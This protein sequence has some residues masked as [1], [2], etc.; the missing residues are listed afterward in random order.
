LTNFSAIEAIAILAG[1]AFPTGV[2]AQDTGRPTNYGENPAEPPKVTGAYAGD[3]QILQ[4]LSNKP[5]KRKFGEYGEVYYIPSTQ[6][7]TMWG[8]LPNRNSKPVMKVPSNS[9][10]VFDTVSHEGILEDQGR[11]PVSFFGKYGVPEEHVLQDA[12][13]IAASSVEHDFIKAG[14]HIVTG[15]VEIEG[16]QPGDVLMVETLEL[17]PRVPYGVVSNR[18]G[19]G[20]LVGE[21][22]ETERPD[23]TASATNPELY[24]NVSIFTPIRKVHNQWY[25]IMHNR[26]GEEVWFPVTPFLGIMGIAPN[27][28]DLVH[29]VPP[30]AH[31]GNLD[32]AKL[33][34]GSTLYL[35]IQVPGAMFYVGDPHNSQGNGEVAL[36]ALEQA[37]RAVLRL[38][39]LKDGNPRIPSS[40]KLAKPFGETKD[41]W[42]PIGLHED[43]DEAMKDAVRQAVNF[44]SEKLDMDRATALAYMS[45]AT[46]YEVSQVVDRTKGVHA[47]I[48]KDDFAET[49][50]VRI[51]P[52]TAEETTHSN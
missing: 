16:A 36:T 21:F 45:A 26:K 8:Y 43:L 15:P 44:L 11:N 33:G 22:P 41:Y 25:G 1:L 23:P 6:E 4:P 5:E 29:S 51:A 18:H 34:V 40:D 10:V 47:L 31:G 32:V 39:L 28:S 20:A 27:R 52:P 24:R 48:R 7:T 9:V 19:K 38:T 35:P 17:K 13:E 50:A 42:I 30:D 12:K 3:Y 49:S 46:D 37:Q 14:P 2:L